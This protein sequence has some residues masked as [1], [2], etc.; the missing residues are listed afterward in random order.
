MGTYSSIIRGV[1][2]GV[3]HKDNKNL[4]S[5]FPVKAGG[6]GGLILEGGV[7]SGEYG[8]CCVGAAMHY[9]TTH[10]IN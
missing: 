2:W 5:T 4:C 9:S 6:A 10:N 3:Y 7:F 1:I 8:M